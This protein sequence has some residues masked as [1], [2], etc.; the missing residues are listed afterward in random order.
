MAATPADSVGGAVDSGPPQPRS[1][2]EK[3][4]RERSKKRDLHEFYEI[5]D[6][7]GQGGSCKIYRIRKRHDM[8]GGSSREKN[9]LH[10]KSFFGKAR[11]RRV[12]MAS[13]P[14]LMQQFSS[15]T[16]MTTTTTSEEPSVPPFNNLVGA[17]ERVRRVRMASSP[18]LMQQFSATATPTSSEPSIVPPV[19]VNYAA[20]DQVTALSRIRGS[21]KHRH[22]KKDRVRVMAHAIS[23]PSLSPW[24]KRHVNPVEELPVMTTD[25][26]ALRPQNPQLQQQIDETEETERD[27]HIPGSSA[28]YSSDNI[29]ATPDEDGSNWRSNHRE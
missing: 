29:N 24:R 4:V 13:S 16:S 8:I 26:S 20:K 18:N 10:K 14:A 7:I 6:E 12:R 15:P 1:I 21:F 19:V 9:V 17:N 11:H 27:A 23:E 2:H 28:T 22:G 5:V 3:L 25:S